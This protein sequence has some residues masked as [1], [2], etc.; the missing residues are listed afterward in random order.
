[1]RNRRWVQRLGMLVRETEG[2]NILLHDAIIAAEE[3]NGQERIG[4]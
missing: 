1:M 2:A 3:G 4:N